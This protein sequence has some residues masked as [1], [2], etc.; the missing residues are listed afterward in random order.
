MPAIDDILDITTRAEFDRAA[1]E[2]FRR[3]AAEC[4]PY[5]EYLELIGVDPASVGGVDEI[6]FLPIELFKTHRVYC[7]TDEP[8]AKRVQHFGKAVGVFL[9]RG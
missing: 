6:P 2:I 5:R 1:M 7:G 4:P 3:Q 9:Q 8:E